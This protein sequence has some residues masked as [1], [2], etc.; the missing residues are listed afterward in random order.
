MSYIEFGCD[1]LDVADA[2]GDTSSIRIIKGFY[3]IT[4]LE[5]I[6]RKLLTSYNLEV[7]D[8]K[9]DSNTLK[10]IR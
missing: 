8:L 2:C 7:F 6:I 9:T 5:A 3:E 4:A 10:C 1:T